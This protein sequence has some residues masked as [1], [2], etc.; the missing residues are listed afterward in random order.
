MMSKIV[1]NSLVCIPFYFFTNWLTAYILLK[2]L[3]HWLYSQVGIHITH[4][5]EYFRVRSVK[6]KALFGPFRRH[7]EGRLVAI[8]WYIVNRLLP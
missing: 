1:G 6:G 5:F 4:F 8:D 3:Q 2:K 7:P